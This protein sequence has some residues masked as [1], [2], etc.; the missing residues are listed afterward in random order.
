MKKI[1]FLI[2]K[3]SK[4]ILP[5]C[6]KAIENLRSKNAEAEIFICEASI[7][8]KELARHIENKSADILDKTLF[9]TDIAECAKLLTE[10]NFCVV[11]LEHGENTS[12]KFDGI[13]YIFSEPEEVDFDSYLKA[14]Q[15]IKGLPW[16]ILQTKRCLIRETTVDDVDKLY[17]IYSEPEMTR[18]MEG[19]F[20][21]PEDEKR[22]MKDYID[23]VYGFMGFGV[24]SVI[25][26]ESNELIGRAGFSIRKGFDHPEIG[27]LI[28]KSRQNMGYA[29]EVASAVLDYGKSVLG[30]CLVQALVKRG[31]IISINLLK[32]L[33]FK[34]ERMVEVEEDIYGGKYLN[35]KGNFNTV[36]KENRPSFGTYIELIKEM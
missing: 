22:Y 15:R 21:D 24:W 14:Y 29:K 12:E 28:S 3:E 25:E 6:L 26:K 30:F 1:S 23:K 5:G 32:K 18:Y 35:E 2:D 31:N 27:F 10:K 16:N 13:K 19:L 7:I 33:G 17:K 36:N 4:K 20:S 11:A 8:D 34:I 9:V